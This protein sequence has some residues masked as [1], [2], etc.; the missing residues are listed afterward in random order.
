MKDLFRISAA[1]I[2]AL[3]K[4]PET[5]VRERLVLSKTQYVYLPMASLCVIPRPMY[6][7]KMR[8]GVTSPARKLMGQ[9]A[10]VQ[11]S[12]VS[13]T[14]GCPMEEFYCMVHRLFSMPSMLMLGVSIPRLVSFPGTP[15]P[16]FWRF[17]VRFLTQKWCMHTLTRS[18]SDLCTAS[19][20]STGQTLSTC[21]QG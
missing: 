14:Q 21:L 16:Q 10:N 13:L 12:K 1:S 3:L 20:E 2:D 7:S 4:P 9:K 19:F 11:I 5:A 18:L 8:Y 15:H 6:I 17:Q